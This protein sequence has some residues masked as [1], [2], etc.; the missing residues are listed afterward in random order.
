M[1]IDSDRVAAKLDPTV[2]VRALREAHRLEPPFEVDRMLL[3]EP[4]APNELLVWGGWRRQEGLAVKAVSVFPGN[5]DDGRPNLQS[6]VVLFDGKDGRPLAVIHGEAFTRIK[7]AADSA[8]AASFLARSDVDTVAVIGAGAQAETHVRFLRAVRPSIRRVL[9]CN[10]TLPRA[11]ALARTLAEGGVDAVPMADVAAAVRQAGV[12]SCLTSS[13][14]PVIEGGWLAAGTHVDLVGS[15]TPDMRESDDETMRRGRIFV[16][17]RQFTVAAT[18]DL[19]RPIA[20]GVIA[21]GDIEG[22]LFDLSVER[23]L[24]RRSPEEITVFKNGGGGHL[25]LFV[26]R[27][28]FGIAASEAHA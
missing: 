17:T 28:L 15:F 11:A 1:L 24:G 3:A 26:A 23:C 9:V 16:D 12:V 25:D 22:D 8:L 4:G 2:L 21:A 19:A 13:K 7:T 27:A 18:G 20:D 5:S 10:R 14:T 6:I